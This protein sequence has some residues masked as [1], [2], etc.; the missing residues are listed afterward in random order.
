MKFK[1]DQKEISGYLPSRSG[2]LWVRKPSGVGLILLLSVIFLQWF[3]SCKK[4][5]VKD[6][7]NNLHL[8]N[9]T[10]SLNASALSGNDF[11]IVAMPD[12]QYETSNKNGA[13]DSMLISQ[14]QWIKN[15]QADSSI[16]YVIGLGDI[17]DDGD[18]QPTQWTNAKNEYYKLETP[19]TGFPNGIPYGLAVGNH[20]Q[21]PNQGFPLTDSTHLYN[22]YFG[23]S[24]FTG[25]SYYGGAYGSPHGAN[26]SHYDLFTAGGVDWICI[27]LEYDSQN[28]DRS[29]ANNWAY[30]L[31]GTYASRKAIIVSHYLIESGH[32]A[33]WGNQGGV[34]PTV[35]QGEGIYNKM[36]LRPNVCLM[37]CG[38]TSGNTGERFDSYL[39]SSKIRTLF[40]D[41]QFSANGGNGFM[42][43]MHFSTTNDRLSVQTYSPWLNIFNADNFS[44]P[45]FHTLRSVDFNNSSK[46]DCAFYNVGTWK[47]FGQSNVSLGTTGDIPV[48]ADYN[49]DGKTD[50]ATYTPSTGV[51]TISGSA[52]I[53]FG[54]STDIPVPADYDGDGVDDVAIFRPSDGTWHFAGALN[55]L[56]IQFGQSGDIPV[57]GDYDGDGHADY[58]LWRPSTHTLYVRNIVTLANSTTVFNAGDIPVPGDYIGAGMVL[59]A[60][61]RP[62]TGEWVIPGH[63]TVTLGGSA[64]DIPAPGYYNGNGLM[65]QAYY[66]SGILHI[67]GGATVTFGNVPGGD[68]LLALPY[69][70][71]NVFFP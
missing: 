26:D 3:V 15:H 18:S 31:L 61:Y 32:Q 20:D 30:N 65:Q 54:L 69:P 59:P 24:H 13:K 22:T 34:N 19:I 17:T 29:G 16:V 58:A 50:K 11:M 52:S 44:R 67:A 53:T 12:I 39:G 71:R 51:W 25:R 55:S 4:M 45:L 60:I 5:E 28:Q 7:T 23:K 62:S 47:T 66:R 1:N 38:H 36:K 57:P 43:L 64:G 42:R 49:G 21:Y 27:Y 48:P 37:L 41:Y 40:S 35:S 46:T 10:G 6:E 33:I 56:A 9:T 70:V 68:K 2:Y 63:T 8:G 14:I